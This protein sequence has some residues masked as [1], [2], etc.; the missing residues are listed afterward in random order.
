[1]SERK[2][3]LWRWQ[4]VLPIVILL[5]TS[6][7]GVY[8]AYTGK[9]RIRIDVTKL[10]SSVIADLQQRPTDKFRLTYD[11][12]EIENATAVSFLLKNSG[13]ADIQ[14][15]APKNSADI[16]NPR[17]ILEV[18]PDSQILT[19]KITLTGNDRSASF[20]KLPSTTT[21][22]QEF[23]ISLMN[24]GA[25]VQLDAIVST[26]T[27]ESESKIYVAGLGSKGR[28][29]PLG[30]RPHLN[31]V[32][33]V[34]VAIVCILFMAVTLR[35]SFHVAD[36][37]IDRTPGFARLVAKITNYAFESGK[38][39]ITNRWHQRLSVATFVTT[40][41]VLGLFSLAYIMWRY[42]YDIF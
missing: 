40:V 4:H 10:S 17:I 37:V 27:P 7:W 20:E 13:N 11:G 8:K 19:S 9:N 2:P 35:I 6:V 42:F 26:H 23:L 30:R 15:V 32:H 36:T 22:E 21:H 1:M 29:V 25:K 38:A 28:A 24:V 14:P 39:D 18:K 41:V 31:T 33:Y 5:L 16:R 12:Q 3:V 34:V